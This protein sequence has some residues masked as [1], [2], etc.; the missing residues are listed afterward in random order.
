M[1]EPWL[2]SFIILGVILGVVLLYL[3]CFWWQWWWIE[4]NGGWGSHSPGVGG[5]EPMS[6]R[7][8]VLDSAG[9]VLGT[10]PARFL[11]DGNVECNVRFTQAGTIAR[12]RFWIDEWA[13]PEFADLDGS[14]AVNCGDYFKVTEL[15][16]DVRPLAD[17]LYLWSK[18]DVDFLR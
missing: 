11:A 9:V 7:I 3:F 4:G 14:E 18:T 8:E 16:W 17:K 13:F 6:N 15:R 2:E 12:L 5:Q 10:G 1:R